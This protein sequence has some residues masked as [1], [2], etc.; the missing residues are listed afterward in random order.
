MFLNDCIQLA[1]LVLGN[2][3]TYI[4]INPWVLIVVGVSAA[5]IWV[6]ARRLVPY[7]L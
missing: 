7:S 2:V 1:F 6:L 5:A 3:L 4:V